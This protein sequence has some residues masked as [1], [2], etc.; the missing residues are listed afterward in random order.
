MAEVI[1]IFLLEEDEELRAKKPIYLSSDESEYST[2]NTTTDHHHESISPDSINQLAASQLEQ[3]SNMGTETVF[4]QPTP[5]VSMICDDE[6]Q[7]NLTPIN[8]NPEH[9]ISQ[10]PPQ[11]NHPIQLC[12]HLQPVLDTPKSQHPED[13]G[14]RDIFRAYDLPKPS[15]LA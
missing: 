14:P 1:L 9:N 13:R 11:R 3:Q 6:E 4:Y 8:G 2:R 10:I 15:T 12:Q 7:S 5:N